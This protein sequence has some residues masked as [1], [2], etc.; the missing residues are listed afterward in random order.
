MN[1]TRFALLAL[2]VL[3]AA[4]Q[5]AG[6]QPQPGA[7]SQPAK[8]EDLCSIEGQVLNAVTGEPLRKAQVSLYKDEDYGIEH[9]T[10]TD[11]GGRFLVQDLDPGRYHLSAS[12]NGFAQAQYGARGANSG[13]TPLS[14]TPGQHMRDIVFRLTPHGVIAGRVLDEDGEPVERAQVNTMRYRSFRG[15]RQLVPAGWGMT[16]DLG[17]YRIFGLEPGKY[18]LSVRYQQRNFMAAED[19]TA[20]AKPDEEYVPTYYPGTN[21][22]AGAVTVEVAAGSVL[23][24]TDITLKKARTLR[25]R[26]RVANGAGEGLPNNLMVRLMPREQAYFG[27]FGNQA[28]RVR[29]QD[30]TFELRGVTPGAYILVAQWWEDG[31]GS[32]VRQ[33]VDVGNNDIDNVSLLL[34]PG[35]DLK[36]QVRIEGPPGGVPF[37]SLHVGLEPQSFLPMGQPNA[38]VKQDGSFTLENVPA[39]TFRVN[40]TGLPEN[41]YVKMIRMGD[42]D[43]LDAGLDLTRGGS[44]VLDITLNPNGGQVDGAVQK[45]SQQPAAGAMIL[46]APDSH[47]QQFNLFKTVAADQ[48]GHFSI[49]GIAPG[50]YKLFAFEQMD[51]GAYQDPEFLKPYENKGEAVAMREGSHET[52]QLKVIP[53]ETAPAAKSGSN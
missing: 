14:L 53:A 26:G 49:K 30:G 13:G 37:E 6:V 47:R 15:K 39:D 28:A 17:E 22:P 1:L 40:V 35:L 9:G 27:F 4:Q 10:A 21:D 8:P 20:G 44:G 48:F 43:A 38:S 18:Y 24:G 16:D 2:P 3:L 29:R 42:T 25:V 46:L 50:D 36:G 19:R 34:M 52:A 12:R 32:S 31:K 33:P 7:K 11:A 5:P 41:F 51:W 45:E 23:G